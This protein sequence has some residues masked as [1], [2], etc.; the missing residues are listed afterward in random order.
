MGRK[1]YRFAD[2]SCSEPPRTS[3][4]TTQSTANAP[5]SLHDPN[6]APGVNAADNSD[7]Q[8]PQLARLD[9]LANHITDTSKKTTVFL[10]P[11]ELRDGAVLTV[12]SI[13]PSDHDALYSF[14]ETLS[15]NTIHERF[16]G[17]LP[18]LTEPLLQRFTT[19]DFQLRVA[20]VAVHQ[21][22]TGCEVIVA[23]AR[24]DR[25]PSRPETAEYAIVVSDAYQNLGIGKALLK[26]LLAYARTQ[27]VTV[28]VGEILAENSRMER[29]LKHVAED[30]GMRFEIAKRAAMEEVDECRVYTSF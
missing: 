18:H 10:A 9:A 24:Y 14:H 26:R 3:T 19:V 11:I 12:R 4:P 2:P 20:I 7:S 13:L 17:A 21:N 22:S 6:I 23:V 25:N 16:H 29:T 8:Q 5:I 30:L 1:Y 15:S 27:G 28:I